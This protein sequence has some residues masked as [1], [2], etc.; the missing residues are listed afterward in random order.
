[1]NALVPA[2]L[3]SVYLLAVALVLPRWL[4]RAAWTD[5]APRLAIAAWQSV[6]V[7]VLAAL[8]LLLLA[9][10]VPVHPLEGGLGPF[11]QACLDLQQSGA[12]P[13]GAAV[14]IAAGAGL[15]ALLVRVAVVGV[16]TWRRWAG[17]VR[18]QVEALDLL[19]RPVGGTGVRVLSSDSAAAF[20]LPRRGGIVVTTA[21]LD[22]LSDGELEAVLAHE[23]AHLSQR[24]HLVTLLAESFAAVLPGLPGARLGAEQVARLV[25]LAADD[26][27]LRRH[28]R[29][30]L[31]EALLVM[32]QPSTTAGALAAGGGAVSQRVRRLVAGPAGLGPARPAAA[33]AAL[34]VSTAAPIA[35]VVV[36]AL[37][38]ATCSMA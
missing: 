4:V 20:C 22:L 36:P 16:Q 3:L 35:A 33:S 25:E 2:L 10:A 9:V 26:E 32:A 29:L 28:D 19:A 37:L 17:S 21:A 6:N 7:S 15:L 30:S 34:S 14:R 24:H 1:M 8:A 31:A 23:R 27:V 11:L 12:A 38:F 5:R 18:R 13:G